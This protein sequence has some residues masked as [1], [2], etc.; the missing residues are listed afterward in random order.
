MPDRDDGL[1]VVAGARIE[2][3]KVP[4]P[5]LRDPPFWSREGPDITVCLCKSCCYGGECWSWYLMV[6][7]CVEILGK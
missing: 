3:V 2:F 6:G 4:A 7:L 1:A 5:F